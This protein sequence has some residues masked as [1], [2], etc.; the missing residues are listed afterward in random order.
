MLVSCIVF[1]ARTPVLAAFGLLFPSR[2]HLLWT[3]SCTADA[4]NNCAPPS[5]C[6]EERLFAGVLPPGPAAPQI[7]EAQDGAAVLSGF[8]KQALIATDEL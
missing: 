5:N 8:I 3:C 4:R 1:S 2:S 6:C 7:A